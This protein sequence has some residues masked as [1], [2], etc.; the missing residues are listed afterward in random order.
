MIER[1]KEGDKEVLLVFC[2]QRRDRRESAWQFNKLNL[3]PMK[4]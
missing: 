2:E 4:G 3:N 1:E